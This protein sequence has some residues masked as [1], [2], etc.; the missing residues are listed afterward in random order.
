VANPFVIGAGTSPTD[1][2]PNVTGVYGPS[3]IKELLAVF[4]KMYPGKVRIGTI[5][6]PAYPNTVSNLKDLKKALA[7]DKNI[8]LEEVT[9]ANSNDVYQAALALSSKKIQAF[10]LINDLT[11]FNSFESV[12]RISKNSRI[13]IFTCDAERL[14]DGALVVYGFEYFVSGMQA[15]RLIDRVVK[16]ESPANI[17]FEKYKIVTYGINYDV[18]GELKITIP[19]SIQNEADA[20]VKNGKL[21][22]PPFI[23]PL[24]NPSSQIADSIKKQTGGVK[25]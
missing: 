1:H 14:K 8:A 17:P 15:A 11:V 3:P 25:H 2:P 20:S 22:K 10:V 6:N 13:P 24:V 18:A 9:V 7:A 23:L 4:R 19:V 21:T 5:Y 16:G 12:V